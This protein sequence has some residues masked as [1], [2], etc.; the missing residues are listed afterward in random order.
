MSGSKGNWDWSA[1]LERLKKREADGEMTLTLGLTEDELMRAEEIHEFRFPP[2]L[3]SFLSCVL[4]LGRHFYDWRNPGS[5]ALLGMFAWPFEGI[6]FDIE[7]NKFWWDEWGPRPEKLADAFEIAK[8]AVA[9][10]PRLIPISSHRFIPEEP[11]LAGNPVFSVY[12]TDIIEYGVD[13]QDYF[14]REF[15]NRAERDAKW[16]EEPSRR[17]RFWSDVIDRGNRVDGRVLLDP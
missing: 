13:L 6:A 3:R 14:L 11:S 17:I 7:H 16:P 1:A 15:G 4:P 2:D 9:A 5:R 8:A 12:Q 10:A